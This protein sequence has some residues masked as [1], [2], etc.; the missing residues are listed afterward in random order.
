MT[1]RIDEVRVEPTIESSMAAYLRK[2]DDIDFN[3]PPTEEE[4]EWSRDR[5]A[6]YAVET[7]H[8]Q[9][10]TQGYWSIVSFCS[11]AYVKLIEKNND[12]ISLIIEDLSISKIMDISLA[13]SQRGFDCSMDNR[14]VPT[15]HDENGNMKKVEYIH[16]MVVTKSDRIPTI[17]PRKYTK[18][19]NKDT[20]QLDFILQ[21]LYVLGFENEWDNIFMNAMHDSANTEE[22]LR[23]KG[24]VV[25]DRGMTESDRHALRVR[26]IT[27]YEPKD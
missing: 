20:Y 3:Y 22:R 2:L 23:N 19:D 9:L 10:Y 16:N 8:D 11:A 1:H 26:R 24:K 15:A 27:M 12:S 21:C 14:I 5:E 25:Y 6:N 13:L 18:P 7:F 4:L 17:Q